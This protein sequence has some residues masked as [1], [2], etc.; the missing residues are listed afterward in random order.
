MPLLQIRSL[1]VDSAR[2]AQDKANLD[3]LLTYLQKHCLP[4]TGNLWCCL[5]SLGSSGKNSC[6]VDRPASRKWQVYHSLLIQI[7][8]SRDSLV[9]CNMHKAL[10]S[11]LGTTRSWQEDRKFKD[12][13]GYS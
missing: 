6:G 4:N 2:P 12:T 9:T 13:L 7:P 8:C 10:G 5:S 1:T 3:L 11:S